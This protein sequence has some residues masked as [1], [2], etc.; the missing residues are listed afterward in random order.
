[1]LTFGSRMN[2]ISSS[3]DH[4]AS[5]GFLRRKQTLSCFRL[6]HARVSACLARFAPETDASQCGERRNLRR[7][8]F[9]R[10]SNNSS[11]IV[12]GITEWSSSSTTPVGITPNTSAHGLKPIRMSSVW[13][14]CRP[15][16]PISTPLSA[17]GS[18]RGDS[19]RTIATFRYSTSWLMRYSNNSHLGK[20]PTKH[21]GDYAQLLKTLY[22]AVKA[23]SLDQ[24]VLFGLESLRRTVSVYRDFHN[25]HRPHQGIHNRIPR[26]HADGMP[27]LGS[28][29]RPT[30]GHCIVECTQFLGGLLKSYSHKAA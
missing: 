14:S 17:C 13:T 29:T 6:Q 24:L 16:V 4:V 3:T 20:S 2:A 1:M 12:A 9:W 8:R 15:T 25:S 21:C 18:L 7:Q 23:E 10:F 28:P 19:A 30:R 5:C 11:A 27:H 26:Q 22:I